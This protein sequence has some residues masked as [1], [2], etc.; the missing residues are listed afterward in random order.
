MNE[1]M[2]YGKSGDDT[3]K[4]I[5]GK[6]PVETCYKELL[7]L[8]QLEKHIKNYLKNIEVK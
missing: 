1:I 4:E 3:N 2:L 8:I 6:S 7:V 5:K